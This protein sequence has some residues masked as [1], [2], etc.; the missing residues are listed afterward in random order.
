MTSDSID[1][2]LSPVSSEP[3]AEAAS[4]PIITRSS[5]RRARTGFRWVSYVA[6]PLA[7]VILIL[8][9]G[10][11][12]FGAGASGGWVLPA[13][14]SQGDSVLFRLRTDRRDSG[15]DHRPDRRVVPA[16]Q[17][18]NTARLRFMG[19]G[20]PADWLFAQ[21][22]EHRNTRRFRSAWFPSTVLAVAGW[23]TGLMVVGGGLRCRDL[24]GPDG[25][26][27]ARR[28]R[29]RRPTGMT[30]TGGWTT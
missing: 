27:P 11:M 6:G 19:G 25:R 23:R 12:A 26:P 9:L 7:A 29:S 30:R 4:R 5:W 3:A 16:G 22:P 20:Q 17:A 28:M 1:S 10:M 8:G 14:G 2:Q 13:L 21:E 15:L 24:R 18:G